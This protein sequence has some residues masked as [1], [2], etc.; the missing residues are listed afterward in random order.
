MLPALP[1]AQ[2][3]AGKV[4]Y[5]DMKRLIDNAPQMNASRERLQREFAPR[6]AALKDDETRLK[7]LQARYARDAAIM[8][9]SD[10]ETLKREVDTLER[11]VKR[12]REALR[13][14]LNARA[15]ADRDRIWQQINETV[16]EYA[17]AHGYDLVVP[18]PVVYA[19]PRVDLTDAVL[20]ALRHAKPA[21]P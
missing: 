13:S 4:G 16:I 8:S 21:S 18:S 1:R 3:P 9:A 19:S 10:A 5:V 11:S 12:N 20:D 14:E 7:A 15:G 6:D 2:A 17:R